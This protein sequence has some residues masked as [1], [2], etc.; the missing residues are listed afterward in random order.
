MEVMRRHTS[1]RS[2]HEKEDEDGRN[3]S[4]HDEGRHQSRSCAWGQTRALK[5][6][7]HSGA[8]RTRIYVTRLTHPKYSLHRD[9]GIGL[10][11]TTGSQRHILT[12]LQDIPLL[13]E[14]LKT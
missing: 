1:R 3:L 5:R 12:S 9:F 6:P 10:R 2:K 11:S 8:H 14:G 13:I 7:R 4:A